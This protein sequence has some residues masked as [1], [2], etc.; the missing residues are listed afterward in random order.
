MLMGPT[1][2]NTKLLYPHGAFTRD[3]V[4]APCGGQQ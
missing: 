1:V 4:I 3:S 2:K